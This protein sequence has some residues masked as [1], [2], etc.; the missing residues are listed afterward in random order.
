MRRKHGSAAANAADLP[1]VAPAHEELDRPQVVFWEPLLRQF[2]DLKPSEVVVVDAYTQLPEATDAELAE[3]CGVSRQTVNEIRNSD[4]WG[5][6]LRALMLQRGDACTGKTLLVW[7]RWLDAILRKQSRGTQPSGD[8]CRAL[9]M[10]AKRGGLLA[11]EVQINV[12]GDS[13]SIVNVVQSAIANMR[14]VTRPD[15]DNTAQPSGAQHMK[16]E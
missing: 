14:S 10:L 15:G 3:K 7:E 9:E 12:S 6:L 5:K 1:A 13:V 4:R 11:P 8:D 16:V 2:P